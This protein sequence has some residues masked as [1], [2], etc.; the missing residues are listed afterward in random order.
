MKT[1][2]AG[3]CATTGKSYP[4]GTE[5]TKTPSGW[6]LAQG[7]HVADMRRVE[8]QPGAAELESNPDTQPKIRTTDI[9]KPMICGCCKTLPGFDQAK[10]ETYAAS[11]FQ[12]SGDML[13]CPHC[14]RTGHILTA[15]EVKAKFPPEE[16]RCW[17]CGGLF[18]YAECQANDGD[19]NLNGGYC[20][21]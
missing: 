10:P 11:V 5:I 2:Y 4:A 1:K 9:S 6:V 13:T 18:T 19:W 15:A 17:E 16:R 7:A 12:V 21:C 3:K 14:G 8:M 20:G